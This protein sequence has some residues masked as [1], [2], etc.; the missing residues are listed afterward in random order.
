MVRSVN[1]LLRSG[2]IGG[3][4]ELKMPEKLIAG[5]QRGTAP[6]LAFSA[7]ILIFSSPSR[8]VPESG[9]WLPLSK[10]S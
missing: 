7:S 10:R 1:L 6:G 8:V 3:G 9:S 5:S 4:K 2:G